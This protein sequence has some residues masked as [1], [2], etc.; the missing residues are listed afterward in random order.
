MRNR[1]NKAKIMRLNTNTQKSVNNNS[2]NTI[3]NNKNISN[4]LNNIILEDI[5]KKNYNFLN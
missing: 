1:F 3:D 4:N 5:C 2:E